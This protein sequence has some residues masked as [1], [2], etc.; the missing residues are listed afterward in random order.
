MNNKI[1]SI[2][3]LKSAVVLSLFGGVVACANANNYGQD[4]SYDSSVYQMMEAERQKASPNAM[5][6]YEQ[7]MQGSLF[8]MYPTYWKLDYNLSSQDPS[9]I[10]AFVRQYPS[11]VMGEKL[12]ADYAEAKARQGDYA[13]VRAV[14]G[15]IENPD[16]SEACALGLGFNQVS[17]PRVLAQ[18]SV[19]LDTNVKQ[20]LCHKFGS[21]MVYHNQITRTDKHE[22]LIRMMRIDKRQYSSKDTPM[23]KTNDIVTL[24]RSLGLP[25]DYGTISSIRSNP[26]G[27]FGQ[28]A[29]Q[30]YS[31][32]NQYLYVYAISLLAQNSYWSAIQQLEYDLRANGNKLSDMARRYAYRS[33]A[34][35]RMNMN[36]DDG[37]SMDAVNWFRNSLGEPF[38]FEEAE[39]Y[40]QASIYFSQWADVVQAVRAMPQANANEKQWQYWL[41]RGLEQ[42]GKQGEARQIYANIANGLGYYSLLARD[43]LGQALTLNDLGGGMPD[44]SRDAHRVMQDQHFAR[45]I[46]LI[47]N[48]ASYDSIGREWN[49]AV[50]EAVK[51]GD[52][53]LLLAAAKKA[54]DLGV[55]HR[56]IYAMDY[57]NERNPNIRAGA[58]SHPMPYR[59]AF[60]RY[61]HNAGIDPAWALGIAHKESRFQPNAR[62]HVG[63]GGLMQIM[64]NTAKVIARDMGE[65]LGS[66]SNADTN[67]R[68]GTWYL[69]MKAR[70]FNGQ[71]APATAGYNAGT[72]P[73][74]K[75]LPKH[76]SMA[77]DQYVEAIPYFETRDYVKQVMTNATIY[78]VLLGNYTPISQR[79]GT[80]SPSW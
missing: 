37:F 55:Y 21:E 60:V 28:F 52:T 2:N 16:D 35:K 44:V 27:F 36:T 39:D 70:D 22:R 20:S 61:A 38:N 30:G 73:A 46:L 65:S 57:A 25:I 18:K 6:Q 29:S 31:D 41:A 54:H 43:R 68:Y 45:A 69:S 76:G 47:Q 77:G 66:M 17:D 34:V 79:M 24:A 9:T 72:T 62:S 64:P 1:S 3:T 51:K 19:W 5:Y 15:S 48:N 13:S 56:S 8:A 49:W 4:Y 32:T 14:A 74:R 63:A 10:N 26:N 71:L 75:W 40:A 42:T 67:I 53:G 50:R 12:A 33:I 7:S 11:T 58:L 23:D 80:V 78:G 59:D